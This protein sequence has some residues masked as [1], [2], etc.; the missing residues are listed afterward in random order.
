MMRTKIQFEEPE[1][2]VPSLVRG[3]PV[4]GLQRLFGLLGPDG[5]PT[6]SGAAKLTAFCWLPMCLLAGLDS[7]NWTLVYDHGF[8]SDLDVYSRY[9]LAVFI[10]MITDRTTDHRLNNLLVTF[11]KTGIISSDMHAGY[12]RQIARGDRLTS[13]AVAE[14]IIVLSA[15][16]MSAI[17]SYFV[18]NNDLEHWSTAMP[19]LSIILS[20]AGWW[21]TL[22]S[23]PIYYVLTFRWL[24]RLIAWTVLMKDITGLPLKLVATHP[25]K[26]GGLGFLTIFPAMFLPLI[27]SLSLVFATGNL[28][29]ILVEG[30]QVIDLEY[31]VFGWLT[32][33]F[34]F[35]VG[36]LGVFTPQ[37][38]QLK[39]RAILDYGT[40]AASTNR[41]A[42]T[43]LLDQFANGQAVD[44]DA[45]SL[46]A[47]ITTCL[48][49]IKALKPVPVEFFALIPL[50]VS[51]LLPLLAV[52]ATRFPIG[53][54]LWSLFTSVI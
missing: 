50:I 10:L 12:M 7:R 33:V 26:A 22:V 49:T 32:L 2:E 21:R 45:V 25:D 24:W 19:G 14:T 48:E 5:L 31:A 37:L 30:G 53:D 3:G 8:F 38:L 9:L 40:L 11:E 54:L 51:A 42:E 41:A 47:D 35:F 43:Q 46:I 4:W 52:A 1:S 34:I 13:S 36:P 18:I 23:N 28:Q 15:V 27:F 17:A 39:E 29:I 20:P 16:A 44:K 6:W